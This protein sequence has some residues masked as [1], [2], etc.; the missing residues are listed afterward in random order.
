[1]QLKYWNFYF[2]PVALLCLSACSKKVEI[3]EFT[4]VE[5]KKVENA[6]AKDVAERVEIVQLEKTPQ[7]AIRQVTDLLTD[8]GLFFVKDANRRVLLFDKDGKFVCQMGDCKNVNRMFLNK[9]DKTLNLICN[10][11]SE[12]M[13]LDYKGN[14][15]RQI[16]LKREMRR[17]RKV[18]LTALGDTVVACNTPLI[19][20]MGGSEYKV[21][22]KNKEAMLQ[23]NELTSV[24]FT[25]FSSIHPLCVYEDHALMAPAFCDTI[26]MWKDGKFT[27]L[28]HYQ[29]GQPFANG[30][31][32]RKEQKGERVENIR[33]QVMAKGAIAELSNLIETDRFLIICTNP[34]QVTIWDKADKEGVNFMFVR[35]EEL[36]TSHGFS[37]AQ[38]AGGNT[39]M[40]LARPE[41]DKDN[42]AVHLYHLD[43][44]LVSNMKKR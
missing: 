26:Y 17:S 8:D 14:L 7:S 42:P 43:S 6:V 13:E 25:P 10:N 20:N 30:Y 1:M 9:Q 18:V 41:V 31:R 35:N 36:Q 33:K 15:L 28:V 16:P 38:Y 44:D 32:I 27:P 39:I 11:D 21:F 19:L 23:P 34:Y 5:G 4:V 2:L 29:G 22:G 40:V 12:L 24:N 37:M 3:K